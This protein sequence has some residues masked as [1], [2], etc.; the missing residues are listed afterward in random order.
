[1]PSS[2]LKSMAQLKCVYPSTRSTGSKQE[3]LQALVQ[4]DSEDSVAVAE[5][6]WDD[7]YGWSAAMGGCKVFSGARRG[8][9]GG[10]VALDV[11]ECFDCTELN[12]CR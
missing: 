10:G 12:D 5:T 2:G 11:S 9:R 7:S 8:R 4:R 3:E 1:M 6:W